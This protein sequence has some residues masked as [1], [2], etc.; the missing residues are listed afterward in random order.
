LEGLSETWLSD[1]ETLLQKHPGAMVGE[2]GLCKVARF[3]RTYAAG[4]QAAL[5]LQRDA[6]CQQLR[7]AARL[8]RPV[9]IHC[10]NQQG[11]MLD[12]LK[13]LASSEDGKRL[14]PAMALHSF[15]G[16]AHHVQQLLQWERGLKRLSSSNKEP[17]LY[18]G[19][20]HAVNFAMCTSAKSR[21][22]GR[23]AVRQVPRDRLLAES[24]VHSDGNVAAG[25]AGAVAYIAWALSEPIQVVADLTRRNGLRFLRRLQLPGEG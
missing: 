15:T 20:S 17:L 2:I 24:D 14:P 4:K 25:T 3:V 16:T 9:S 13:E 19:F 6:F 22:Q 18:F 7:L 21:R 5:Q 10:V 12:I 8:E 23:Q 1:L 11:V